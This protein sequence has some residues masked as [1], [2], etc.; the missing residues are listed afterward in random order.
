[1]ENKT[2]MLNAYNK[3]KSIKKSMKQNPEKISE[4]KEEYLLYLEELG[5]K[6]NDDFR[7]DV[8]LN[9]S[10]ELEWSVK[11]IENVDISQLIRMHLQ[12]KNNNIYYLKQEGFTAYIGR[13][14]GEVQN[15]DVANHQ[16]LADN[17]I[18]ESHF[19]SQCKNLWMSFPKDVGIMWC[20]NEPVSNT[21]LMQYCERATYSF[22]TNILGDSYKMKQEKENIY[23]LHNNQWKKL[24]TGAWQEIPG[25]YVIYI[26]INVG[27]VD[28]DVINGATLK[29]AKPNGHQP[30]IG[31]SDLL[32]E[33]LNPQ[34]II[35]GVLEEFK[36]ET[37]GV[38][39]YV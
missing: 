24:T 18:A 6:N 12:S 35:D 34:N 33:S 8:H 19:V 5:Y 32:A 29:E 30:G 20:Q 10:K 27:N 7:R 37:K 11:F 38:Y 17:S 3:Q 23:L 15:P 9:G 4:K 21:A 14:Y 31:L 36:K 22:I 39:N 2:R 13:E 16:F 1:M 28:M 26:R 25:G